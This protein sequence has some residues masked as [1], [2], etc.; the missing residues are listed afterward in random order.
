MHGHVAIEMQPAT[1]TKPLTP[2]FGIGVLDAA[3]RHKAHIV[4]LDQTAVGATTQDNQKQSGLFQALTAN[5]A[6]HAHEK[7][8]SH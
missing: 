1:A 8:R 2:K 3:A 4:K 5:G 7:S 6:S